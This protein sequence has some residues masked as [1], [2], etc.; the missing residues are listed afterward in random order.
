[1][2]E[3]VLNET[4][5]QQF[6][7]LNKVLESAEASLKNFTVDS[8]IGELLFINSSESSIP[9]STR[10]DL[11]LS[12]IL[13][14]GEKT[15]SEYYKGMS[16]GSNYI[17]EAARKVFPNSHK[18]TESI[19][20]FKEYLKTLFLNEAAGMTIAPP[21]EMVNTSAIDTA[22][23]GGPMS[24]NNNSG[25]WGTLTSLWNA[26]TEGGSFLGVIQFI[27]DII[28]L[29][30]DFIFPGVGVVA[31][32][33]NAI[34]Y[35]CRGEYMLATISIIAAFVMGGG[36]ALKLLKP[37]A[38][39]ASPILVKLAKGQVDDAAQAVAKLGTKDSGMAMRLLRKIV[40]LIGG[41]LGSATTMLGR[42]IQNFGKVTSYIP[43]LGR[44]LK[45]IFDFLGSSITN[46]GTKMTT[47]CDSFKLMDT[48]LA[49][50]ALE[51]MDTAAKTGST[52]KLSD[53]GR[54]LY[55]YNTEGKLIGKIPSETFSKSGIREIRYGGASGADEL[56]TTA[57]GFA[58]YQK[59]ISRLATNSSLIGGIV[60]GLGRIIPNFKKATKE[61]G[62]RLAFFVGKEIYKM[63]HNGKA[64]TGKPGEWSEEEIR[65]HGN[66]GFNNFIDQRIKKKMKETGAVYVP[67]VE[68][69]SSDKEAYNKVIAYQNHFAKL[70]GEPSI[71]TM[72]IDNYDKN[73]VDKEFDEFFKEIGT[74]KITRD[75]KEDSVDHS[76][77]DTMNSDIEQATDSTD[78]S[79]S[80]FKPTTANRFSQFISKSK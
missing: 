71:M 59:D 32:L 29:V 68:L 18:I 24:A 57:A 27:I 23:A 21:V 58:K 2:S 43:G 46:F 61:F 65:G 17:L 74:G 31:D 69:D 55:A 63:M 73:K 42:F 52:F 54:L 22:I 25:F 38:K 76:I 12:M 67:Y 78:N 14:E 7:I 53:D 79:S 5:I 75:G 10:F 8:L 6:D 39:A 28:G 37:G 41:A 51:Q 49:K 72:I 34:I 62:T 15:V 44:L 3:F 20:T 13:G 45:P 77:T 50:E 19:D 60:K 30:G 35:Y 47:F 16:T 26:C 66:A 56:F 40:S 48:K 9:E 80:D 64:W 70:H 11:H 36:D 1:M 4:Q 33:I